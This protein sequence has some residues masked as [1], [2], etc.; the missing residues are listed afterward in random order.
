MSHFPCSYM[1]KNHLILS[2]LK[3]YIDFGTPFDTENENIVDLDRPVKDLTV[4]SLR[5]LCSISLLEK[6]WRN[7]EKVRD[8]KGTRFTVPSYFFVTR[9]TVIFLRGEI[10]FLKVETRRVLMGVE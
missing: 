9:V 8:H 6:V 4:G 10:F 5:I 7:P 2:G 1:I 3:K